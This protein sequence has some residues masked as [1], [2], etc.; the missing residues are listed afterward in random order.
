MGSV[1][2][3]VCFLG[4]SLLDYDMRPGMARNGVVLFP[5]SIYLDRRHR[6]RFADPARNGR[7]TVLAILGASWREKDESSDHHWCVKFQEMPS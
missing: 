4:A 2:C 6:L 5:A 7:I 3:R 1:Q